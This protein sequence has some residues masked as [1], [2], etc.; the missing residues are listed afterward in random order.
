ME[1]VQVLYRVRRVN[2]K[3]VRMCEMNLRLELNL[4]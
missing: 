1:I 3:L 2:R 4:S